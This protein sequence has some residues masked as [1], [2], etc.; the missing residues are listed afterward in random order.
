MCA[1]DFQEHCFVGVVTREVG[2][3]EAYDRSDIF[4]VK[5]GVHEMLLKDFPAFHA[6]A[7]SLAIPRAIARGITRVLFSKDET[8][9]WL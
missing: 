3:D 8:Y 1:E 5:D 2:K 4:L 7:L 6:Y 9:K